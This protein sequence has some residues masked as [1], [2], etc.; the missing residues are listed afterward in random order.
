MFFGYFLPTFPLFFELFSSG[1]F[2]RFL[3]AMV[4]LNSHFNSEVVFS[5][6]FSSGFFSRGM[7]PTTCVVK[8]SVFSG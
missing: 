1:S 4:V 7:F 8:D 5:V 3:I 6:G 2:D